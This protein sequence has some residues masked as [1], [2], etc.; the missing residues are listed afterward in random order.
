MLTIEV[1]ASR[2]AQIG[3]NW[4]SRTRS[5]AIKADDHVRRE[6]RSLA[7]F[8]AV[9]PVPL[10]RV[11]RTMLP[12]RHEADSSTERVT[13]RWPHGVPPAQCGGRWTAPGYPPRRPHRDCM[14][15]DHDAR[16]LL[17]E[18]I[19]APAGG[20]WQTATRSTSPSLLV[21]M[22]RRSSSTRQPSSMDLS[23][24]KVSSGT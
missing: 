24:L 1:A 9:F 20:F 23:S 7:S 21:S 13:A 12:T 18:T 16:G 11:D 15:R 22:S 10:A 2:S 5:V 8:V 14:A 17:G 3:V 6:N 19:S 4:P